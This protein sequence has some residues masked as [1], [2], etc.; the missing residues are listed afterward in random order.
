MGV[1]KIYLTNTASTHTPLTSMKRMSL[2][3]GTSNS[4]STTISITA[5]QTTQF[6]PGTATNNTLANP[7]SGTLNNQGWLFET[8][9]PGFY[10]PGV[11]TLNIA[12]NN[13]NANTTG[14][15]EAQVFTVNATSTGLSVIASSSL[16]T[17]TAV[18]LTTGTQNFTLNYTS[19]K[20]N[21]LNENQYIYVE[22]YLISTG[23][24]LLNSNTCGISLDNTGTY[25][26]P[27]FFK[28]Y[29]PQYID[30]NA[31]FNVLHQG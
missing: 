26:Q 19:T 24:L 4:T 3:A 14:Q 28:D 16:I 15:I 6:I 1:Q 22:V 21:T 10:Y 23:W 18:G 7:T 2:L 17:S 11:W 27:P 5:N 25:L 30:G 13:A 9:N 12:V 20:V 29:A 31:A 8:A